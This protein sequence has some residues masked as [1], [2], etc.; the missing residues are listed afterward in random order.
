MCQLRRECECATACSFLEE[1]S[2]FTPELSM[3]LLPFDRD[4]R[5]ARGSL[6]SLS[7]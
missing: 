4:G 2:V 1:A 5:D 3:T 7:P 6:D